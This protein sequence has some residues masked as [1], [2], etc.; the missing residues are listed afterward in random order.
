M[1]NIASVTIDKKQYDL[2]LEELMQVYEISLR[3]KIAL[4]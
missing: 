3:K 2:A 1:N 4:I